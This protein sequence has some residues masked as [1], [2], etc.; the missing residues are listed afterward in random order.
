MAQAMSHVPSAEKRSLR[1]EG[2]NTA[3]EAFALVESRLS[4]KC[5]ILL[6]EYEDGAL[7]GLFGTSPK[8]GRRLKDP[9]GSLEYRPV[10]FDAQFDDQGKLVP[11]NFRHSTRPW[12]VRMKGRNTRSFG[13]LGGALCAFLEA[14]ENELGS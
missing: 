8:T 5:I 1:I 7:I 13:D 9:F 3:A 11:Y 4:G 2:V 6:D 12:S 14:A 10:T